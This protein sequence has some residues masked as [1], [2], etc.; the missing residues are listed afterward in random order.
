MDKFNIPSNNKKRIVIAGMGFA[1]LKLA[2]KLIK[3]NYQ[4]V[5]LD[6]R[7]FHQF[8]P[9]FYQVATA[10]LEPSSISFPVR[11][12]FQN[13]KNIH[14]R[15]TALERVYPERKAIVTEFGEL[16][17]DILVLAMGAYT[18]FFGNK[19]LEENGL[20]M[21]TTA[22]AIFLR[23]RILQSFEKAMF[24]NDPVV[25][26]KLL[27][28]AIVGG[29]PTGV[30]LA[31]AI[32][33]MRNHILP[34]D[35]PEIDFSLMNVMLFESS[36]RLLSSMSP[37][38]SEKAYRFLKKLGVDVHLKTRIKGY[39]KE[40]VLLPDNSTYKTDNLIWAAGIQGREVEGLNENVVGKGRRLIV[41]RHNKVSGY[42]D[43]YAIGD[44]AYMETK[45]Y[46]D[47]HPQVA[48]V[49][50]Q[51]ANNLSK[52][53]KKGKAKPFG[54]KDKGSM[55]TIGRNMAVVDLPWWHF[56]GFFAWVVWLFIHLMA[57]VGVKNRLFIFINWA[58]NYFSR[59]QSLRVLIKPFSK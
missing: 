58:S 44:L 32:A 20:S 49:A 23:N 24:E 41:D 9:L 1:G 12:L 57:I 16:S 5:I 27:S 54:Y 4:V 52:L 35:Y 48:Q 31:G 36:E 47:G 42:E 45:L 46:A 2:R 43:I 38:A 33:E 26:E 21:K 15:C 8:Q 19:E 56:S 28:I 39:D 11:K 55:A 6:P 37:K 34:K 10:G 50:I 25:K 3:S 13:K 18:N 30:E 22:E 59:D 51:Q 40:N 14:Y 29:G 53:L 17:Y 7:N